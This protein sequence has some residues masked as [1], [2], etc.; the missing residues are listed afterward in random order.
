MT[1]QTPEHLY[2]ELYDVTVPDWEGEIDF[3]RALARAAKAD[4]QSILEVAC[5]TGRVTLRLAADGVDITGLDL[6][7]E[8]L[9]VARRQSEGV[10]NVGWERGDMRS[11]D[12]GRKFGLII[13]PGHS[14]QFMCTPEDQLTALENFRR[15]LAPGG[16]LVIHI[17][18]QDLDWLGGLK[19]DF[20]P[21]KE[22]PHPERGSAIRS[23]YAWTYERA[24]Q[25]ATVITRWQEVAKDGSVLHS[26]QSK[27]KALHCVFRF[28]M[29]HLL[30]RAGF[31]QR[32]VHGDFFQ[33]KLGEDSSEMIWMAKN[34]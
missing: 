34:P 21:G 30:A 4:G 26:W 28:E 16:M 11:F 5:G 31:E 7:E 9:A 32:I 8:M 13:S 3:Y 25:T 33:N 14:F 15:H 18:H 19:G 12:L 22:V 6:D 2:A 23:T 27:P 10:P 29:E 24:S 17:D 20:E 1:P